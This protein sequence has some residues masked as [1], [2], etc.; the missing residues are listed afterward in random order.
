MK[1]N[2]KLCSVL[3]A[4]CIPVL[5]FSCKKDIDEGSA[6]T[7][8]GGQTV[9]R[10]IYSSR[11]LNW[12]GRAD[13]AYTLAQAQT[14]FGNIMSGWNESRAAFR[15]EQCRITI[16]K[17]ALGAAGGMIAYADVADG[18]EYEIQFDVAFNSTFELGKGGKLGWGFMIGNGASGGSDARDGLG[19]SL[20]LVWQQDVD[21]SFFQAYAYHKDQANAYGTTYGR[22]PAT[23]SITPGAWYTV[24]LYFKSNTGNSTNGRLKLTI[25]G[26]SVVDRA[27]RWTTDDTKRLANKFCFSNFRGGSTVDWQSSAT[28][29][30]YFDNLS[31]T[32]LAL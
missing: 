6:K 21:G 32:R 29:F 18:S 22:Y 11:S 26:T 4:L 17:D 10:A 3:L 27:M 24:K 19:G 14:D 1:T 13:A 23:G 12:N 2:Q 5:F 30:I 7:N 28:S 15:E 16:L 20:R 8:E 9:P 31:W 25:N